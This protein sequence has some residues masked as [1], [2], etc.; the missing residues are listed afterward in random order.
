MEIIKL[1]PFCIVGMKVVCDWRGLS[2]EMPKAWEEIRNRV[3]EI[4]NLE[5]NE[6]YDICLRV[7][8]EEFTQLVGCRVFEIN[9]VPPGM[10]GVLIPAASYAY[11]HHLRPENE[12]ADSFGKLHGW[13]KEQG[14]TVDPTDFK[15]QKSSHPQEDGHHLY[16]RI[17]NI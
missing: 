16:L 9:D 3:M 4:E 7:Q 10:T 14:Y 8:G 12:I 11:F 1:E 2:V 5:S 6:F 17:Q 15:I 13:V